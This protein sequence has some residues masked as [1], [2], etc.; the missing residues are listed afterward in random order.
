MAADDS[1]EDCDDTFS[2]IQTISPLSL[3]QVGNNTDER[4]Q[5][6][7]TDTENLSL[8]AGS[9][10][11]PVA[12]KQTALVTKNYT[13]AR[14]QISL[15]L[16][17]SPEVP[18]VPFRIFHA[19][20]ICLLVVCL[21]ITCFWLRGWCWSNEGGETTRSV[22]AIVADT[23]SPDVVTKAL[24]N[25]QTSWLLALALAS[26]GLLV[27]QCALGVAV[28]SLTLLA[29]AGH[30]AAD[31]VSYFFAYF[32]ERAQTDLARTDT[33]MASC[34]DAISALFG[35]IAVLVPSVLAMWQAG[36]RLIDAGNRSPGLGEVDDVPETDFTGMGSALLT[37]S[38]LSFVVNGV[39]L[40]WQLRRYSDPLSSAPQPS[41]DDEF[42]CVPCDSPPQANATSSPLQMFH[43]AFHPGC[44]STCGRGSASPG[45]GVY[46][47]NDANTSTMSQERSSLNVSGATLHIATDVIRSIIIFTAGF[48]I[49]FRVLKT[50]PFVADA[51]C[52]IVVGVCVIVG[53]AVMFRDIT[54][55]LRAALGCCF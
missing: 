1:M 30:T 54:V 35:V 29:D 28:H 36:S 31:A 47:E 4:V 9:V 41:G 6:R 16:A 17:S 42:T 55:R 12:A 50:T 53:S 27:L 25:N 8:T 34:V 48:L 3:L 33:K 46:G 40:A 20:M 7:M 52:S 5:E 24:A 38:W 14:Q 26:V 45:G 39:L 32:A 10:P 43:M 18:A 13:W 19:S 15:A 44:D 21:L 2:V 37:F 51:A 11:S 22:Q 49:Y 23:K